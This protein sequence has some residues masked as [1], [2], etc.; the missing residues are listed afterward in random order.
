[1]T[2]LLYL[3]FTNVTSIDKIYTSI[4]KVNLSIDDVEDVEDIEDTDIQEDDEFVF[5]IAKTHTGQ[6]ALNLIKL[7]CDNLSQIVDNKNT[8]QLEFHIQEEKSLYHTRI[9]VE[10]SLVLQSL[11]RCYAGLQYI[12]LPYGGMKSS[13]RSW[14]SFFLINL[15]I[16]GKESPY[17]LWKKLMLDGTF[18]ALSASE[19]IDFVEYKEYHFILLSC[20]VMHSYNTFIKCWLRHLSIK[21]KDSDYALLQLSY[22]MKNVYTEITM[23]SDCLKSLAKANLSFSIDIRKSFFIGKYDNSPEAQVAQY[24]FKN[25]KWKKRINYTN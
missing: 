21:F 2:T 5:T 7:F 23:D 16:K 24:L 10:H 9:R 3:A 17:P 1:M 25:K 11:T 14:E 22:F 20:N 18:N 4:K 13:R 6:E 12:A 8:I 15:T 19:Q